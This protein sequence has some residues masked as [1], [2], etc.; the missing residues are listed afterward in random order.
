MK[1]YEP[2]DFRYD[3]GFRGRTDSDIAPTVVNFG[4]GGV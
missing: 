1:K 3:E 2:I 4:G